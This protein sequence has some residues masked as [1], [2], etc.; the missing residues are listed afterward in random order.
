MHGNVES[1]Y[2]IEQK[3]N[4]RDKKGILVKK[5]YF[6]ISCKKNL[7]IFHQLKILYHLLDCLLGTKFHLK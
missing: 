5:N 2:G 7:I 1:L 3:D 4:N 6:R